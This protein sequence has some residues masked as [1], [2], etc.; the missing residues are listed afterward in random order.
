V[1]TYGSA[2]F[3]R[4][5]GATCRQLQWWDEKGL[6]KPVM[7]AGMRGRGGKKRQYFRGHLARA[8]KLAMLKGLATRTMKRLLRLQFTR[9]IRSHRPTLI[10]HT[11]VIPVA[12]GEKHR[13]KNK[14]RN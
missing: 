11:L 3:A 14:K 8:K 6:L 5:A 4:L 12:G 13:I 1:K 7:V 2:E 10:G 9:V